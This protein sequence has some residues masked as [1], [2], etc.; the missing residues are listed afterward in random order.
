MKLLFLSHDIPSPALSDTLPLYY[1]IRHLSASYGH[2]ITLISFVSERSRTEDIEHLKSVCS[3]ANP[4]QIQWSSHKKLV[5]KAVKNSILNLPKNLR[6]GLFVNELDYYYDRRMD[7]TVKEVI[8]KNNFELLCSTRQ[9]ANYVVDVD[10]PK[11]VQPFDALSEWHRQV[12]SNSRGLKKIAYGI[13]SALNRSYEKHIYE[14]FDACLVVTQRDKE[15]FGSLNPR[16]RCKVV[17]N[18]VDVDYFSHIGTDEESSSLI[19]LAGMRGPV[20]VANVLYFYNEVFPLILRESPDVRLYLVGR[21]PAKEVVQLSSDPLVSV[22]GYVD[23]VRPYI[24]KS[25]VFISPEILGTGIKNKVLEAMSMGKAVVTTTLGAQGISVRSG[26]HLLIADTPKE[27]AKKTVSLLTD[28][29][30]RATIGAN[31]RKLIEEQYSWEITTKALNE[32]LV[33]IVSQRGQ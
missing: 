25:T 29:Q 22:T 6:H 2:D 33:N 10:A 19:L 17:P 20:A 9:M 4:I 30:L 14:E 11:I 8:E 24:A 3:V 7:Q 27:F 1:L 31:A 26:E 5:A 18:G 32:L 28:R 23:D 21:D 13:R 16:I 12:S 15:L